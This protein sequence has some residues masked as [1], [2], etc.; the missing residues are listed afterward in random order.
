MFG[1]GR[2]GDDVKN[3]DSMIVGDDMPEVAAPMQEENDGHRKRRLRRVVAIVLVLVV[4]IVALFS[5]ANRELTGARVTAIHPLEYARAFDGDLA[6]VVVC[7]SDHV[8]VDIQ[9]SVDV[10]SVGTQDLPVRLT[11]GPLVRTD[12]VGVAVIDTL[13][14]VISLKAKNA[15]IELGE[16]LETSAIVDEVADPVD[17]GLVE[18]KEEPKAREGEVGR[19]DIYDE[20]FFFLEG[21]DAL[22]DVGDHDVRVVA[23]DSHGNRSEERVG[24]TVKDPLEGVVLTQRTKVLEYAKKK[25]D[26]VALV[27][28]DVDG[29]DVSAKSVDLSKVGKTSVTYTLRKGASSRTEK[30]EFEVRDTKKPVISLKA[31]SAEVKEG[32]SFDPYSL[33]KS[34]RDEVDGELSRKGKQSDGE[35]YYVVEGTVDTATPSKYFLTV[36]AQDK[37]GNKVEKEI[38]VNVERTKVP[39]TTAETSGGQPTGTNGTANTSVPAGDKRDYVLNT[40]THK[41]HYPSCRHVESIYAENREDVLMTREEIVGMG[42]D[43]CKHCNP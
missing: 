6:E 28:C 41:F 14:P 20:G 25:A 33:V 37:N 27:S 36:M 32:E 15:T 3:D 11:L 19:A 5:F 29:V 1:R 24:V 10:T 4:C 42:Y 13:P 43:P 40:N 17:G 18:A 2:N 23:V 22:S 26:P 39:T 31:N 30:L 21:T 34:V 16:E 38:V 12:T 7:S 9:G 8:S 35:G